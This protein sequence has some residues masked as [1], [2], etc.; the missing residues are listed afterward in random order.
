MSLLTSL[1]FTR[2]GCT[3]TSPLVLNLVV[4]QHVLHIPQCQTMRILMSSF[5]SCDRCHLFISIASTAMT[6]DKIHMSHA[7]TA[8][9]AGRFCLST[10]SSPSVRDGRTNLG[11]ESQW[12]VSG[13]SF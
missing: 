12:F 5:C 10:T 8:C 2:N 1:A 3:T 11:N 4:S 6:V 13:L 7:S 9:T